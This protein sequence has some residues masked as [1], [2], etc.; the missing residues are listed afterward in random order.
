MFSFFN[1]TS[2]MSG[3]RVVVVSHNVHSVLGKGP[4]ENSQ[5]HEFMR[6]AV[7]LGAVG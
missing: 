6:G 7:T 1:N 2:K 4:L 5:V 3:G